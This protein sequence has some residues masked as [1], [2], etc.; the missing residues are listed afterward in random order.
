MSATTMVA[1]NRSTTSVLIPMTVTVCR[2]SGG[3]Q[4]HLRAH[5]HRVPADLLAFFHLHQ[6]HV[7]EDVAVYGVHQ[8]ALEKA[9]VLYVHALG[10]SGEVLYVV[11][12]VV[13]PVLVEDGEEGD[14]LPVYALGRAVLFCLALAGDYDRAYEPRVG[15]VGLVDVGMVH[16]CDGAGVL[17]SRTRPLRDLPGVGVLLARLDHVIAL[18][19]LA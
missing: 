5:G 3:V 7:A 13:A 18:V 6:G 11:V 4:V 2:A 1:G 16:P 17:R 9:L 8:V 12:E 10:M 19:L 14:E 15:V